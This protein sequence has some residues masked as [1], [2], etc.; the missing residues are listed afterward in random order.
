MESIII[1]KVINDDGE[2]F[3]VKWTLNLEKRV[4]EESTIS[5]SLIKKIFK[6]K[7]IRDIKD[8]N[9]ELHSNE[10]TYYCYNC[11]GM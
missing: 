8:V 9:L 6:I 1:T 7:D 3:D 11:M 5:Y 2:Q 4:I 10:N